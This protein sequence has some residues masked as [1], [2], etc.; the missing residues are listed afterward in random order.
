VHQVGD[1]T[2]VI[3]FMSVCPS[4]WNNSA[5]PGRTCMRF[6]IRVFFE[7]LSRIFKFH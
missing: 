7:K 5:T 2:K 1:Q 6:D 4:A 3:R